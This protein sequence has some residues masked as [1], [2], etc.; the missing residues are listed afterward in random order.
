MTIQYFPNTA[1][2]NSALDFRWNDTI[3]TIAASENRIL[4]ELYLFPLRKQ[5]VL[6]SN[7]YAFNSE[8]VLALYCH[9][10]G[11]ISGACRS[12]QW[13]CDNGQC[14][15]TR[16]RCDGTT[17]CTDRSDEDGCKSESNVKFALIDMAND[18]INM[19]L[20]VVAVALA[21]FYW[22]YP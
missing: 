18:A 1:D 14:I 6:Y 21:I 2:P 19:Y 17:Q 20:C 12:T 5:I 8:S 11:L 22:V 7:L 9:Y 4:F 3:I 15:A 13:R 10:S 16:D